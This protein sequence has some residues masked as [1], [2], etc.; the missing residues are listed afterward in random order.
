MLVHDVAYQKLL[1]SANDL[2]SYS[3]KHCIVFFWDKLYVPAICTLQQD[4]TYAG[5]TLLLTE[6]I[7]NK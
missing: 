1:T 2:Q 7:T 3:K 5:K 6:S 4:I